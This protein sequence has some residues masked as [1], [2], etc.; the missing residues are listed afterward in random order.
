MFLSNLICHSLLLYIE[1]ELCVRAQAQS[2]DRQGEKVS[3]THFCIGMSWGVV[4]SA[5]SLYC[6]QGLIVKYRFVWLKRFSVATGDDIY[7]RQQKPLRK[8]NFPF[9][10][11]KS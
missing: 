5:F 9:I 6:A 7:V 1:M 3:L 4:F 10:I 8:K 2:E 11:E